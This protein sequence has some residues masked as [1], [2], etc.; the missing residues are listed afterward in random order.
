MHIFL[1]TNYITENNKTKMAG[2]S[3]ECG[4][5]M[6]GLRVSAA[7]DKISGGEP[8]VATE[9][10]VVTE[11]TEVIMGVEDDDLTMEEVEEQVSIFILKIIIPT[12]LL[13]IIFC[14]LA[15]KIKV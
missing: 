11:I 3:E 1:A 10:A 14:P 6:A 8:G 13:E 15:K 12:P 7:A 4:I 9:T 2:A 5:S